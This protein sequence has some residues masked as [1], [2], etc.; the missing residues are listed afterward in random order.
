[1]GPSHLVHA[2][3]TVPEL[4]HQCRL[5]CRHHHDL[6]LLNKEARVALL[7]HVTSCDIVLMGPRG[8]RMLRAMMTLLGSADLQHL[9][10]ELRDADC[11]T[12]GQQLQEFLRGMKQ[13]LHGLT[14]IQMETH[15]RTEVLEQLAPSSQT[16]RVLHVIGHVDCSTLLRFGAVCPNLETLKITAMGFSSQFESPR[17]IPQLKHLELINPAP[18]DVHPLILPV[19]GSVCRYMA[20]SSLTTL[21][22][23]RFL[24]TLAGWNHLPLSL[25]SLECGFHMTIDGVSA[26]VLPHLENLKV[27]S[28]FNLFEARLVA[29]YLRLAP[30]LRVI[31][32]IKRGQSVFGRSYDKAYVST[33]CYSS[34]C[35][36]LALLD[37]SIASSRLV[38]VDGLNVLFAGARSSEQTDAFFQSLTCMP[39]VSAILLSFN[40][41][42]IASV[43]K[44][45]AALFP[46]LTSLGIL[47]RTAMSHTDLHLL[48]GSTSLQHVSLAMT[49]MGAADY[50]FV[51]LTS[52]CLTLKSLVGLR[53]DS[54]AWEHDSGAERRLA[55][56]AADMNSVLEA[57]GSTARV[58]LYKDPRMEDPLINLD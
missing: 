43:P 25:Q 54:K 7:A 30:A 11:T 55:A 24:L 48:V 1:M 23:D 29:G 3:T 53:L 4:F 49:Q 57:W 33:H 36:D 51:A 45:F 15:R 34:S 27:L 56:G 6:R 21:V 26:K 20:H 16:L 41:S 19:S 18:I 58:S 5:V 40:S 8:Q 50:S 12:H 17:F 10:V 32:L 44:N 22:L 47:S 37:H 2:L 31:Q 46:A 13:A 38:F 28:P 39:S 14:S 42:I 9:G 35:E 52:L